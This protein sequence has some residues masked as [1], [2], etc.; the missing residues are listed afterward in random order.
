MPSAAE[1]TERPLVVDGVGTRVLEA[2]DGDGP[3]LLLLH[4]Y[5][6]SA[7]T[8]RGLMTELAGRGL[9]SA[10]VDLPG[11]GRADRL[12]PD[13]PLLEQFVAVADGA[14]RALF[15]DEPAILVGNSMGAVTALLRAERRPDPA[16]VVAIAP[17]GIGSPRWFQLIHQ[18]QLLRY[19]L[20]DRG[21]VPVA[22]VRTV[23]SQIY[24]QLAFAHPMRAR[25]DVVTRHASHF[26][27]RRDVRRLLHTGQRL[28]EELDDPFAF[29]RVSCPVLVV[30]GD[31]DR[32]VPHPGGRELVA[33]L[34]DGRLELLP[35]V[36]HSPQIEATETVADLLVDLVGALDARH[37]APAD[38]A[39]ST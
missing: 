31:R 35:G 7:D 33:A 36:G 34:P 21:P 20:N 26:H 8:W 12:A 13:V 14:S 9:R 37:G 6:D 1:I 19:V 24:R 18:H 30:W 2:G 16:A 23:I 27:S 39:A 3:P 4:G 11:F 5:S 28:M 22:L 10:A 25:R 38:G 32:M 29:D 17:A 15:G